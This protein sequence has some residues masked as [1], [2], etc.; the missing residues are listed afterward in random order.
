MRQSKAAR[1]SGEY[2]S[3]AQLAAHYG[4]SRASIWRWSR[5]GSLPRPVQLSPGCT[6]WLASEI[7]ETDAA[8]V[9]E[10]DDAA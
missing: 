6:R 1:K 2:L 9:A 7:A 3:D 8:R 5:R 4:V 10:R